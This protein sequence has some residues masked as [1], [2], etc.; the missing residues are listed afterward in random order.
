MILFLS[1]FGCTTLSTVNGAKVIAPKT[2]K[3]GLAS[4]VQN[5]NPISTAL[6]LPVPQTEV[7]IRYG[8]NEHMDMGS[9]M[10]LGGMLFDFRYQ[11]LQKG[12]WY[13]AVDPSIGGLYS[14]IG[15]VVD[16]RIPLIA[17]KDLNEKWS[18]ATGMTPI[19]QN[20]FAFLPNIRENMKHNS[21]GVFIRMEKTGKRL[22]WGF[23]SDIYERTSQ[24]LLPSVNFGIDVSRK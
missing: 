6:G 22:K 20:T 10:Y 3:M 17:Q 14:P 5:N 11:F 12:D 19:S 13:F 21:M 18:F 23:S 8:L 24:G 1:F 4:S 9:R 2:W 15:G 16:L 7:L